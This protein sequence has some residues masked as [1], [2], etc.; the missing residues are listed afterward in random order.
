MKSNNTLKILAI[1]LMIAFTSCQEDDAIIK[2]ESKTTESSKKDT[3]KIYEGNAVLDTYE[4]YVEFVEGNYSI[5]IGNLEIFGLSQLEHLDGLNNLTTVI[6]NVTLNNNDHLVDLSGLNHLSTIEGGLY[7][8]YNDNL[9]SLNGLNNLY[10]L[11]GG[12]FIGGEGQYN[13]PNL[14]L[15][16]FCA[17]NNLMIDGIFEG[18][19]HVENNL[20]NP[21]R[22]EIE[23][24]QCVYENIY[25]GSVFL[26]TYHKYQEFISNNYTEVTGYL[27]IKG[28]PKLTS[29]QGLES[30]NSVGSDFHIGT[31]ENLQDLKGLESLTTVG[32]YLWI[33][34]NHFLQSLDGLN[35][36]LTVNGDLQI[37]D[38]GTIDNPIPRPNPYL[39]N[40]CALDNLINHGSIGGNYIVKN[41]KYN[42]TLDDL[43]NG[44]CSKGNQENIYEGDAYLNTY[45]EYQEF[46]SHKYTEVTGFLHIHNIP[47]LTNLQGLESI[48]SLGGTLFINSNYNLQSLDGLESLTSVGWDLNIYS[49]ENIQSLQGLESLT[50]VGG[51]LN[52]DTNNNLQSLDG[53]GNLNSVGDYLKIYDNENLQNIK[54]LESLNSVGGI[55]W[56]G[57]NNNLQSLDGLNNL[58]MIGS[59]LSI[60]LDREGN[61]SPNSNLTNYCSL[62]RLINSEGLKGDYNVANN[63][64]N[65]TLEDIKAGR[66][67]E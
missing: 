28:I 58:S 30:L 5:I 35:S 31:N 15:Q 20:Y 27:V 8:G 2:Q 43:R 48:N 36:L 66:C 7:I 52:I 34:Q 21:T 22:E 67:S 40:F 63:K 10:S 62:T 49:N 11:R 51:Y 57:N 9:E 61:S 14:K 59:D 25:E 18:E 44:N 19:Y 42:P 16:N 33:V 46:I 54:D 65:P 6:G 13:Y 55:L 4:K 56:I 32:G 29:L 17:L 37:G 45:Q 53:L 12:L 41:N 23:N 38:R 3:K 24:S 1:S 26:D 39:S 47:Q 60:G 64:Y 50:Y